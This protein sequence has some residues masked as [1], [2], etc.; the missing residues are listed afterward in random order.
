MF[1]YSLT[2]LEEEWK[3]EEKEGGK[4]GCSKNTAIVLNI[5]A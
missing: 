5:W 1:C 4:G 2:A 3:K